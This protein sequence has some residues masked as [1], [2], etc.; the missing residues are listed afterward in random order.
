[1]AVYQKVTDMSKSQSHDGAK[2]QGFTKVS[3]I[4]LMYIL[5]A[6]FN[7]ARHQG[8]FFFSIWDIP[9]TRPLACLKTYKFVF[10]IAFLSSK[11][12]D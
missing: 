2:S 1:M 11:N 10:L 6:Q 12:L 3:M 9:R 4:H 7:V 8:F 5:C